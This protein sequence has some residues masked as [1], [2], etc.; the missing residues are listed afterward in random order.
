MRSELK[1]LLGGNA[2][3]K[4]FA[5]EVGADAAALNAVE[6]VNLCKGWVKP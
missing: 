5:K 2:V 1:V 3:T 6:G 4:E